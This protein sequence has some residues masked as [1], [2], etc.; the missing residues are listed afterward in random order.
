[1]VF[2]VGHQE[3]EPY[4]H[5]NVDI[6]IHGIKI[7]IEIC[8]LMRGHSNKYAIKYNDSYLENN[9]SYC[10]LVP[11]ILM[12]SVFIRVQTVGVIHLLI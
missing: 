4:K 12:N 7:R 1:M 10:K 2:Y 11:I 5:H 6:L 9:D 3:T 8:L